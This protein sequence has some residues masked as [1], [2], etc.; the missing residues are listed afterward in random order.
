MGGPYNRGKPCKLIQNGNEIIFINEKGNT[1]KGYKRNSRFVIPKWNNLTGHVKN[2]GNLIEWSDGTRW[3]GSKT[4]TE[5]W[6]MSNKEQRCY[7]IQEKDSL[8]IVYDDSNTPI[9]MMT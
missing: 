6:Y 5:N 7:I 1:A 8:L 3:V 4:Y 9:R 2:G